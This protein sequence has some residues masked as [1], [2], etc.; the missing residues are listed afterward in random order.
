MKE[1]KFAKEKKLNY[2]EGKRDRVRLFE[3]VLLGS[4]SMVHGRY[5]NTP[6]SRRSW[7]PCDTTRPIYRTLPLPRWNTSDAR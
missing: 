6:S 2:I 1:V 7:S 4:A 3:Q 5:V